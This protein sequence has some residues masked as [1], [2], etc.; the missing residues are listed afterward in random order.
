MDQPTIII[1]DQIPDSITLGGVAYKV[2]ETP[3]LTAFLSTVRKNIS[4]TEKSKLYSTIETLQK[5]LKALEKVE[6]VAP[7][8]DL[9]TLK[10]DIVKELKGTF[11]PLLAD[12][13]KKATFLEASQVAD[14]KNRLISENQDKCYPELIVGDTKEDLDKALQSSLELWGKYQSGGGTPG[15]S[16]VAPTV[17]TT[18]APTVDPL[19]NVA[20]LPAGNVEDVDISSLSQEEFKA[21]RTELEGK[22][23]ALVG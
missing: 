12:V 7:T 16:N 6:I 14:Y 17:T 2:S 11:E 10:K 5:E 3:E 20:K 13:S 23:K 1:E 19:P 4:K 9:D 18:V 22:I 21:R 8:F 15:T